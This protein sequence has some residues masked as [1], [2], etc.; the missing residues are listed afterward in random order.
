LCVPYF[1]EEKYSLNLD[2]YE[3]LAKLKKNIW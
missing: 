2:N 3:D 1:I